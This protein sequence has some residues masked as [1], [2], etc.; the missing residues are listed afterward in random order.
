[1]E[2]TTTRR[3]RRARRTRPWA[4]VE[5]IFFGLAALLALIMTV[6]ALVDL[7]YFVDQL[8][9]AEDP[10]T[11]TADQGTGDS[12]SDGAAQTGSDETTE[13][14]ESAGETAGETATTD[15]SQYAGDSGYGGQLYALLDSHP[16]AAYI[17]RNLDQYPESLL[18]F[19]LRFPESMAFGAA[20][21]DYAGMNLQTPIDLSAGDSR[22]SQ[23][24]R[25]LQ[26]IIDGQNAFMP[27]LHQWD[28]RWGYL[29]YGGGL[30][31]CTGCGPTCLSMVS[32]YL[33]G[34]HQNDPYSVSKYAQENGYYV[35]GSGSSWSL[36]TEG[37]AQFGLTATE[38]NLDGNLIDQ[39][40]EAGQPVILSMGPGDFTD[41]GHYI[42][43]AG[44]TESGYIVRD[45]NS[46][47]NS[48]KT[49]TFDQL[50]DQIKNIWAFQAAD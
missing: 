35:E 23:V 42:V 13:G 28:S 6:T 17:L 5:L 25:E 29:S 31:G 44:V 20:Y 45:P 19:V 15:L 47:Q 38:V 3:R 16:E 26:E 48:A 24:S 32:L 34:W 9:G 21:L 39:A 11:V 49:W 7:I 12:Q 18:E 8:G 22:H 14:Q 4:D 33:T 41:N 36:M 46:P 10:A 2:Q 40:L 27:L 50:K 1:M 37:S 43:L 30:L